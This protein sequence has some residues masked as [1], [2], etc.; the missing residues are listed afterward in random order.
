M[1]ECFSLLLGIIRYP[2]TPI[3]LKDTSCS[4]SHSL[5][6]DEVE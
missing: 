5:I 3:H 1:A 6:A 4:L 2:T